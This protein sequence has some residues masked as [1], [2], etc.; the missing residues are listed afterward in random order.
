[1]PGVEDFGIVPVEAQ[2]CGR[3]VVAAAEGGAL[4]TVRDGITG[5]LVDGGSVASFAEGLHEVSRRPFDPDTIR[6]HA[7]SFGKARFQ[8]QLA[9][10]IETVLAGDTRAIAADH[11]GDRRA[12]GQS[13]D[14]LDHSTAREHAL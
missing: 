4:E 8:R 5:V 6:R 1:M 13:P 12:G 9:Q 2:A 11:A 7:E 14:R 3:P 10:E